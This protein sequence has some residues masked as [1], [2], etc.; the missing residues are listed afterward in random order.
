MKEVI[1]PKELKR[2]ELEDRIVALF[3]IVCG[4][5]TE[6]DIAFHGEMV[7]LALRS[8]CGERFHIG[9]PREVDP[10][11]NNS[12]AARPSSR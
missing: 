6:R 5:G 2:R 4:Q 8:Y 12:K 9:E 1:T 7:V 3:Q 10:L 11:P